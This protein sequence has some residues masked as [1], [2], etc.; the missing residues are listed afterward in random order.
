MEK[1][2]QNVNFDNRKRVNMYGSSEESYFNN[3]DITSEEQQYC[4]PASFQKKNDDTYCYVNTNGNLIC[5]QNSIYCNNNYE[6][7]K[8]QNNDIKY[9]IDNRLD[10]AL[11]TL[12]NYL[13]TNSSNV[14]KNCIPIIKKYIYEWGLQPH[15]QKYYNLF[16][17][18]AL[19][20]PSK[21]ARKYFSTNALLIG[22]MMNITESSEESENSE[23]IE[24]R[25]NEILEIIYDNNQ[26][27]MIN[28]ITGEEM[29]RFQEEEMNKYQEEE[30]NKYQ[31][32]EMNRFQEE[33]EMN[34]FQEQEMNGFQEQ[35]T[36]RFQEEEMNRFQKQEM[37]RFQEQEMNRFQAEEEISNGCRNSKYGSSCASIQA[38]KGTNCIAN[39]IPCNKTQYGCCP[40]GNTTK[41]DVQGSNCLQYP[42]QVQPYSPQDNNYVLNSNQNQRI[43]YV[44]DPQNPR[45]VPDN[46]PFNRTLYLY[47]EN[48][49]LPEETKE[50]PK[51]PDM[52]KYIRKDQ[53]PC[54]GCNLE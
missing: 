37:R 47:N 2:Y 19:D 15:L 9:G 34:R 42:K 5:N 35:E 46:G 12:L 7:S 54:W 14:K 39:Q 25:K 40:D 6:S 33:E 8:C 52:S 11:N 31:E 48:T 43:T 4:K 45:E 3:S 50:C 18:I 32:E 41:Y 38:R 16:T 30:M 22:L 44:T 53:I 29:R 26:E 21:E 24:N 27:E 10:S 36:N 28:Q 1:N 49:P 17:R 20:D 23:Q 51:C 13:N